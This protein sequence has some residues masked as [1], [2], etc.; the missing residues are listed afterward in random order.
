M[1][2]CKAFRTATGSGSPYLLASCIAGAFAANVG[3]G[4]PG[5]YG[6]Q[7][8]QKMR[9]NGWDLL[10]AK[11]YT[12]P[13]ARYVLDMTYI[14][15]AELIIDRLCGDRI[16]AFCNPYSGYANLGSISGAGLVQSGL[17]FPSSIVGN[18]SPYLENL[19]GNLEVNLNSSALVLA[20]SPA[21]PVAQ[22]LMHEGSGLTFHDSIGTATLTSAVA[23]D[24]TWGTSSGF[25]G[26]VPTFTANGGP[27]GISQLTYFGSL[28]PF[29]VS[30]WFKIPSAPTGYNSLVGQ[31]STDAT[32]GEGWG[33]RFGSAADA[34]TFQFILGVVGGAWIYVNS[35]TVTWS[36]GTLENLVVTFD[37]SGS[38]AGVKFYLN[39]TSL[40]V[41]LV[42]SD[43]APNFGNPSD[44]T[45]MTNG[46]IAGTPFPGLI[47]A[48]LRIYNIQLSSTQVGAIN[49]ASLVDVPRFERS[50]WPVLRQRCCPHW[51][52]LAHW[53]RPIRSHDDNRNVGAVL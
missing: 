3:I 6:L 15:I 27:S 12:F 30:V 10:D 31:Y 36:A 39:G 23:G 38:A 19:T 24:V 43:S 8:I 17:H 2:N 4:A 34:N 52:C 35:N 1:T 5:I 16:T 51:P 44:A 48:D 46:I 45:F 28:S 42:R 7:P 9:I 47:M 18:N 25:T 13:N 53:Q 50:E 37:G 41:S 11:A 40:G 22:W 21:K 33:I 32:N 29:S 20:A 49:S 14:S 26:S